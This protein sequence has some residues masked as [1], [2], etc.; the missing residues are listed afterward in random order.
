MR[1][2]G[3]RGPRATRATQ[4]RRPKKKAAQPSRRA[5]QI[6][7]DVISVAMNDTRGGFFTASVI[8]LQKFDATLQSCIHVGS[9]APPSRGLGVI[10]RPI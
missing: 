1:H 4:N 9:K 6:L 10:G 8:S 7:L 2:K 5:A 3:L